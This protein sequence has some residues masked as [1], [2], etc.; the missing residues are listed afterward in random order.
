MLCSEDA[1]RSLLLHLR[2]FDIFIKAA[3]ERS[4]LKNKCSIKFHKIRKK[5][6]CW[7]ALNKVSGPWPA[8]LLK[9]SL[10]LRRFPVN[11]AKLLRTPFS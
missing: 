8:T 3:T 2:H 1:G 6:L 4:V 5:N 10:Q 9:K 7:S 11:F